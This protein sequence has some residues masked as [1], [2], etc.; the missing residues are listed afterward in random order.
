[1]FGINR[2]KRSQPANN[3]TR[4]F[5][6]ILTLCLV[7]LSYNAA[8]QSDVGVTAN[9]IKIG[10]SAPFTG[11]A[12]AYGLEMREAI[13]LYFEHINATGGVNG[14]KLQLVALDDGYE[15]DR[16]VANTKTLIEK[17]DVFALTGYY[18]TSPTAGAMTVFSAAKVPLVGSN[19]G[20][21]VL[22]I[23]VNR[24]MFNLKAGYANE[25]AEIVKQLTTI[26]ITKIAVFY[27]NDGFGKAGLEG[28]TNALKKHNLT[29]LGSATV[30]RNSVEVAD[31][32]KKIAALNPQAVVMVTL[33]K[34]TAA[35]V[36]ALKTANATPYLS[37]LSVVGASILAKEL[38]ELSRGIMVTQVLP[39]PW[40]D[41][42]AVVHEYKKLM[43]KSANKELSYNGLEGYIDARVL[44]E[45]LR[46]CGRNPTREKL[47][48][49]LENLRNF[50]LGGF[51]INYSADNH[52]GSTF[53]ESTVLGINGKIVR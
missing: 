19:S 18:G 40:D 7:L 29:L 52:N 8:A 10:M 11:S 24:Y 44:V 38:G 51:S 20:S 17:E 15:T 26:G 41:T 53:V 42:N 49:T 6:S 50:N 36:R 16:A 27:Q 13:H 14:R 4:F 46:Q 22:R 12:G 37:T 28:V 9:S 34:P 30:E 48:A 39:Y 5:T 23:P 31:A 21:D 25:T 43:E 35:F 45:A 1:M 32:V 47:V 3:A 33:Y 2:K